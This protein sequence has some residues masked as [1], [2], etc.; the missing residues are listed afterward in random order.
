M[1]T[2]LDLP[3]LDAK[4]AHPVTS[5]VGIPTAVTRLATAMS[6]A[7]DFDG[8]PHLGCIEID[9]DIPEHRLAPEFDAEPPAAQGLPEDALRRRGVATRL[10]RA[11][12]EK[13]AL[14]TKSGEQKTHGD[15][16]AGESAGFDHQAQAP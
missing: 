8:E 11:G 1:K 6:R 16:R 10:L 14:V 4:G 13:R 2:A 7:I 3:R 9:D 15:L 5:E 12:Q